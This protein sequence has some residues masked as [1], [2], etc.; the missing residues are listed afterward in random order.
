MQVPIDT[1][2][3]Q[4][5]GTLCAGMEPDF[6]KAFLWHLEQFGTSLAELV[7]ETGVSR[8]V[9]NKLKSRPGSSTSVENGMLIAAYYGKTINEFV[10]MVD[11]TDSSRFQALAGLLLPEEQRLLESQIRGILFRRDA[12]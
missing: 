6:Q 9:L 12:E 3:A 8:D 10:A 4:P 11:A 7:R 2:Q 5:I 1:L